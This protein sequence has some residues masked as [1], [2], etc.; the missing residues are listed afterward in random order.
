MILLGI[1]DDEK[2]HRDNVKSLCEQYFMEN[3]QEH[4]YVEF[5]SGE[6]VLKYTG[7]KIHLLFLA[8]E[9]GEVDGIQVLNY[10]QDADWVWR[11]VFVSSHE[12]A[13]WNSFSIKTLEFARKPIEYNQVDK[14]IG[15]AIRENKE[16]V[17]FEYI[18]PQGKIYKT[19]NEIYYMEAAGNYTYLFEKNEKCIINNNLKSWHE[20]ME[21][22]PIIRV[23]K[24]YLVN[25]LHV[26]KWETEK[27]I[28]ENDIELPIGRTY[29][30]SAKEAYFNFVKKK[31]FERM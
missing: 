30:K 29:Y 24:K 4:E 20:K 13:V 22:V 7:E 19:I 17:A 14:W 18:T 1:C 2:I 27:V 25:L 6:E 15:I 16:D 8:V 10:V 11:V 9:M 31:A 3:P 26:K 21:N 5:C 23:H 28:L 12:E